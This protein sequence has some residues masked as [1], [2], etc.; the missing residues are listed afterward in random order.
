[1]AATRTDLDGTIRIVLGIRKTVI[2]AKGH[3]VIDGDILKFEINHRM[4][5]AT[6]GVELYASAHDALMC[7][8]GG[9]FHAL[10]RSHVVVEGIADSGVVEVR[11]SGRSFSGMLVLPLHF[12]IVFPERIIALSVILRVVIARAVAAEKL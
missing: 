1:M 10:L 4:S 6:V 5:F 11:R 3:A 8:D 12:P 7:D 2:V 9:E